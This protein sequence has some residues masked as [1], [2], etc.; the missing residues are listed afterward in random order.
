LKL[1]EID[2]AMARLRGQLEGLQQVVQNAPGSHRPGP[3]SSETLSAEREVR[4][5]VIALTEMDRRRQEITVEMSL[6]R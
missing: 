6:S 1:R 2:E 3:V 5:L 4:E